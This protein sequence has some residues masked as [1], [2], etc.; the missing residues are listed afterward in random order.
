MIINNY[1]S[2][3]E[4]L[5]SKPLEERAG[6]L[7]EQ[8]ISRDELKQAAR[9]WNRE[10]AESKR[11]EQIEKIVQKKGLVEKS[12]RDIGHSDLWPQHRTVRIIYNEQ[13]VPVELF[14][15]GL[16]TRTS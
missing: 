10:V 2:I 7:E 8:G 9:K 16:N 11:R 15:P 3:A 14:F 13:A 5:T 6:W 4:D 1:E 12:E